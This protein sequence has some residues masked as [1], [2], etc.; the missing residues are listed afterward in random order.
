[1]NAE[2]H[3]DIA[4]LTTMQSA[5]SES[6]ALSNLISEYSTPLLDD[7][8]LIPEM[9]KAYVKVMGRYPGIDIH[10]AWNRKKFLMVVAYCYTPVTLVGVRVKKSGLR[11]AMLKL[12]GLN[13]PSALAGD[14]ANLLTLYVVYAD[15]RRDVDL[16]FDEVRRSLQSE[17][18]LA[19]QK[20]VGY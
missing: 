9:Y 12:F 7:V 16:I 4:K 11:P 13:S 10:S 18:D 2:M 6:R 15:F 17:F 8:S 1:M 14:C 20:R 19:A 5:V 3:L